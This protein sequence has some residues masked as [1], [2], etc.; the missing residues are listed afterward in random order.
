M[1]AT[2]AWIVNQKKKKQKLEFV[3]QILI[4]NEL[5]TPR[6][7]KKK[8]KKPGNHRK[9]FYNSNQKAYPTNAYFGLEFVVLFWD[10]N[11]N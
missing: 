4:S 1:W 11:T 9:F 10:Y 5:P 8:R 6:G 2:K 3:E 7:Q